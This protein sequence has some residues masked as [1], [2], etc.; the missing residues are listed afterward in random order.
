MN[1]SLADFHNK[2][3]ASKWDGKGRNLQQ[4]MQGNRKLPHQ[5]GSQLI[6]NKQ[7]T[8]MTTAVHIMQPQ[9]QLSTTSVAPINCAKLNKG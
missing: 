6:T 4:K 7:L 5:S 1:I 3:G 9:Y 8:T 2:N